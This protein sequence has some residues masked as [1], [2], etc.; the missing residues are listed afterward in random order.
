MDFPFLRHLS[1]SRPRAPAFPSIFQ[2]PQQRMVDPYQR[3][4]REQNGHTGNHRHQ[5]TG[6]ADNAERQAK[7]DFDFMP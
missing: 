2:A 3:Y 7:N 1:G 5:R 6:Y 4:S